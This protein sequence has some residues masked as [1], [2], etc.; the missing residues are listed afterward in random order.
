MIAPKKRGDYRRRCAGYA[1]TVV[2]G[3]DQDSLGHLR[4]AL[5]AQSQSAV[6]EKYFT[7]QGFVAIELCNQ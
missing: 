2:A 3:V 6:D 4:L 7:R 1:K 5:R